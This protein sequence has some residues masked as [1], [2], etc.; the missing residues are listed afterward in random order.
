MAE[1][2]KLEKLNCNPSLKNRIGYGKDDCQGDLREEDRF[3][4]LK[5]IEHSRIADAGVKLM[6]RMTIRLLWVDP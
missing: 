2:E 6:D 4:L 5:L 3:V 1:F